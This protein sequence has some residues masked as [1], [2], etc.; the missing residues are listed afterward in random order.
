MDARSGSSIVFVRAAYD[1]LAVGK[2]QSR[3]RFPELAKWPS[4]RISAASILSIRNP[5]MRAWQSASRSTHFAS[6]LF[7]TG[8]VVHAPPLTGAF[9]NRALSTG[10][11]NF[12]SLSWRVQTTF[13]VDIVAA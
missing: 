1:L 12:T 10:T 7:G 6:C 13:V 4:R 8:R 2:S 3:V 9:R 11:L 5:L